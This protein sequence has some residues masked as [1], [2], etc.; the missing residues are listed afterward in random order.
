[1]AMNEKLNVDDF[2][3]SELKST[4]GGGNNKVDVGVVTGSFLGGVPSKGASMEGLGKNPEEVE[5]RVVPDETSLVERGEE[6]DEQ[7]ELMYLCAIGKLSS[8]KNDFRVI[9]VR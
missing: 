4:A 6:S 3:P 8:E 1:M 5:E 9:D 2:M 7:R